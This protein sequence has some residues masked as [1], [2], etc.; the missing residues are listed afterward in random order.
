VEAWLAANPEAG[1]AAR[2]NAIAGA[3]RQ[4]HDVFAEH[5]RAAGRTNPFAPGLVQLRAR[6]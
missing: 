1:A 4:A 3:L 6:R 2:R 5:E